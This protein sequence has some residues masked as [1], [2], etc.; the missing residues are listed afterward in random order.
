MN[1]GPF[2]AP[3]FTASPIPAESGDHALTLEERRERERHAKIAEYAYFLSLARGFGPG[4]ELDDWL[5]AEHEIDRRGAGGGGST[6][7]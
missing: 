2:Q 3:A 5:A 6:R 1:A 4:G 7:P